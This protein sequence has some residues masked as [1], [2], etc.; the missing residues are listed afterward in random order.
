MYTGECT[1]KRYVTGRDCDQCSPETYGLSDD[2]DGCTPCNCDPG[3]SLD[4]TCD[5]ITGQCRCRPYMQGRDCS[6]P[7]Q[8]YFIP[9]LHIVSEAE[10]PGVCEGGTSYGNCTIVV[11]EPYPERPIADGQTLIRVSEGSELSFTIDNVPKTMGYDVVIRYEPQVIGSW[12]DV[13]I[14]L[15]RPPDENPDSCHNKNVHFE[16]EFPVKI[17]DYERTSIALQ[18]VCLEEDKVYKFIVSFHRQS[19]Q[20]PNPKAQILVDSV[21]IFCMIQEVPK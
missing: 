19:Q 18:D 9:K 1:C 17:N 2:P 12:E 14:S 20:E 16:Q 15:I 4:N 3:G 13:R 7:K 5:L 8:N 11:Q 21:S 10:N 6:E